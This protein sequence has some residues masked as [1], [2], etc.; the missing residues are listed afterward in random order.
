[1]TACDRVETRT[2]T[3]RCT[4]EMVAEDGR[5][6]V[7]PVLA[8]RFNAVTGVL[9]LIVTKEVSGEMRAFDTYDEAEAT[10]KEKSPDV[11]HDILMTPFAIALYPLDASARRGLPEL[12]HARGLERREQV[13]TG[14]VSAEGRPL[15]RQGT[16]RHLWPG[17]TRFLSVEEAP[18]RQ[19]HNYSDGEAVFDL[20]DVIDDAA[21]LL[22]CESLS[23]RAWTEAGGKR[24]AREAADEIIDHAVGD[25]W[26]AFCAQPIPAMTFTRCRRRI[27]CRRP[28]LNP[29][30]NTP[31]L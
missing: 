7:R 17:L 26:G 5:A 20:Y 16:S 12:L 18:P 11:V 1:M 10:V 15:G 31:C 13:S 25:S 21:Q 23:L 9:L 30:H 27:W 2:L 24:E 22:D 6:S 4:V 3:E 8:A 19:R 28:N 29:N 14:R